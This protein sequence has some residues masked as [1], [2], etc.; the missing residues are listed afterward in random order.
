MSEINFPR[1]R[2]V[3]VA[4]ERAGQRIDNFLLS[5]LKGVPR[6]H[7]YRLLRK[8]EVRVNKG[9]IG[10]EYRLQVGDL[11]RIPPV[12]VAQRS[13]VARPSDNTLARMESAILFE[14]SDM[15]ILNKPPG[16]AV[17]GGSGLDFGVIEGLRAMRTEAR[18]LELGHRLDRDTSGC[19]V[20]AKRRPFLLAFQQLLRSDGSNKRYLALVKGHWQGRG[21][22]IT[23]PLRKN[24]LQS[25][26][27]MVRVA[28]DG[29]AATTLFR[30]RERFSIASLVEATL[31]TGR[32]HQVR[33]HAQY[34]GHPIAGDE[35]YGDDGFNRELH[36]LGLR[37]LFLHAYHIDFVWNGLKM[38][39]DAPLESG[40]LQLLDRLRGV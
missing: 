1:V 4:E 16:V 38:S 17:H 27:R 26:E 19:L 22:P 32:T 37:R 36:Q 30:P 39:H 21:G 8:G 25:G 9:R 33:V 12:R 13:E 11:V 7:L 15:I 35:K 28:E 5:E 3:T 14:D 2:E 24:I 34:A 18:F 31:V 23:A 10:P 40:L 6:S 20:I 29:K